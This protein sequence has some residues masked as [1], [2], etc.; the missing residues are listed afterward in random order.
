[1]LKPATEYW[2]HTSPPSEYNCHHTPQTLKSNPTDSSWRWS[3]ST[4]DT[5]KSS[6]RKSSSGFS[7]T[8]FWSPLLE[9][10]L[11]FLDF[12]RRISRLLLR[13]LM[14]WRRCKLRS[15]LLGWSHLM[16]PCR[17]PSTLSM[18]DS[19]VTKPMP[20]VVTILCFFFLKLFVEVKIWIEICLI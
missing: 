7:T 2:S 20:K 18:M 16:F 9:M 3:C 4:M 14:T 15:A 13:L 11:F 1:M 5:M 10:E 6:P 8:R 17:L 12:H 19:S